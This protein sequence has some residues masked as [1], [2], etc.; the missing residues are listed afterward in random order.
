M[1]NVICLSGVTYEC[2]HV[3]PSAVLRST[4]PRHAAAPASFIGMCRP[5]GKVRWTRYLGML[6]TMS[7]RRGGF[8]GQ[9][10]H[11]CHGARPGRD[12]ELHQDR[13]DVVVRL[14]IFATAPA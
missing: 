9:I 3:T 2:S 11:L 8:I 6:G 13:R 12:V 14:P 1:Q 4:T 7:A 10:A 5:S